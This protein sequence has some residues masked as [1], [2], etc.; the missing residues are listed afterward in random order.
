MRTKFQTLLGL[1]LIVILFSACA[2][3]GRKEFSSRYDMR[4]VVLTVDD[5]ENVDWVQLA[6]ESG[7]NTIGTHI[8][9]QQVAD[10]MATERGKE[11]LAQ[12][13]K[14]G[15]HVEHQLHAMSDL[16]PRKLFEQDSTM[17]RMDRRG[18]RRNDVN[19]C[20]HSK[21]ALDTVAARAL[22]YAKLLPSTNHRYYFW[23]DDNRPMCYCPECSKYSD[24]EQALI[25]ENRIIREL[26]KWDPQAQLAHLAYVTT[27]PAPRKVK[28]EEGIFLEFAPIYRSYKKPLKD[29]KLGD[30]DIEKNP[31]KLTNLHYLKENL[32]VFPVE[33]AVVLEYWLD[34]S[35]FSDWK[36]PAVKLPWDRNVF[37]EDLKTYAE[38]GLR[39]ITT[40]AAYV[41]D[42]YVKNYPDLS[43]LNEYG[44]G[45]GRYKATP[46]V[47]PWGDT[48][49]PTDIYVS[50]QDGFVYFNFDV[51][52]AD[53]VYAENFTSERDVEIGD[54]VEIF[55]AKDPKMKHYECFEINPQGYVLAYSASYYRQFDYSW[56]P[57]QGFS[58]SAEITENGYHVEARFPVDYL[59]SFIHNG[60]LY[61]GLY[62][63]DFYKDGDKIVERWY[64]WKNPSTPEP[65]FHVPASLKKFTINN[66]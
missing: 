48:C 57:P 17:F 21:A 9:P 61:F 1:S 36:K 25:V 13:Q 14:Y 64:S 55:F 2:A 27:L 49:A 35:L 47:N 53:L 19:L 32:E 5:L 60:K 12:C 31:G 63:G 37:L 6:H 18:R 59:K 45:L 34:V 29:E 38:Y 20:V 46:L 66:K 65:D 23:I 30:K 44:E 62:R 3:T 58:A 41:D 56:N 10:F 52:D 16:L 39:D 43:F 28:P 4:G 33:T 11:F 54:R 40:F 42:E 51:T 24:S 8:R 7:I 26:R 22:H 15:I 50:S